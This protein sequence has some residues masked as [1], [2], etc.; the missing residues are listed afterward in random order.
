MDTKLCITSDN[1]DIVGISGQMVRAVN[2]GQ[3]S[4]TIQNA[5]GTV[6]RRFTVVVKDIETKPARKK[7]LGIF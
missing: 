4:V 2:V 1:T 5:S 3:A 6:S 7:F